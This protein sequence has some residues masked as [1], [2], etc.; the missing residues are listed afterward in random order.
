MQ[1]LAVACLRLD[2]VAE[3]VPQ[4]EGGSEVVG[5]PLVSSHHLSLMQGWNMVEV[6]Q[7]RQ[8]FSSM[9][10]AALRLLLA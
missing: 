2:G 9:N 5:L 6:C 4:V 1:P 8:H 7:W 3:R 10:A